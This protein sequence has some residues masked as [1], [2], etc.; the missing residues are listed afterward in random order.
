MLVIIIISFPWFDRLK[1]H[2][3]HEVAK[4]MSI[5]IVGAQYWKTVLKFFVDHFSPGMVVQQLSHKNDIGYNYDYENDDDYNIIV[6]SDNNEHDVCCDGLVFNC[7]NWWILI[8][9]AKGTTA[10]N[11]KITEEHDILWESNTVN[12]L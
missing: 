1:D 4:E 7:C 9:M 2:F 6:N 8:L 3:P 10:L 5:L 11:Q 12:L